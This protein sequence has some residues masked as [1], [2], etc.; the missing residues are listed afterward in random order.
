MNLWFAGKENV[1]VFFTRELNDAMEN[2]I[3]LLAA[4]E[5]F[6]HIMLDMNHI[7]CM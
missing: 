5:G 4:I 3:L 7:F 2:F 6:F 1:W